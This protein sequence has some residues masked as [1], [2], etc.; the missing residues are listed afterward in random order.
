MLKRSALLLVMSLMVAF[1]A[2]APLA[3]KTAAPA[4]SMDLMPYLAPPP[5]PDSDQQKAELAELLRLQQ[6]RTADQAAYA[7]A[8]VKKDVFRF[9]DVLGD[10]FTETNLPLTAALFKEVIDAQKACVDPVKKAFHR[11]RPYEVD[12]DIQ[13]C[14]DMK[15][16]GD[17]YP[18]GHATAGTLMAVLLAQMAPE[19]K[20][21]LYARGWAFAYNRMIGGVHF[22]SDIEAGRVAGTLIAYRLMQDKGFQKKFEAAKTELRGVL[23]LSAQ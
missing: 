17:S 19:K 21:E 14:V 5:A 6:S 1:P 11:Q 4:L 15:D 22:R 12:K 3:A 2:A 9:A 18:S 10:K 23:G 20:A 7:Q 13:P 8:D 16:M